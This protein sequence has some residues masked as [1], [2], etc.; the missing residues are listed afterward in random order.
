MSSCMPSFCSV[1]E[2]FLFSLV[3][4]LAESFST[5][6]VLKI[7]PLLSFVYKKPPH[8][9][10]LFDFSIIFCIYVYWYLQ[11]YCL[12]SILLY[13]L[14]IV[15]PLLIPYYGVLLLLFVCW[16][17]PGQHCQFLSIR[18][19]VIFLHLAFTSLFFFTLNAKTFFWTPFHIVPCPMS[20]DRFTGKT[21][22]Y[23]AALLIHFSLILQ[24]TPHR[25]F[26]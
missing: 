13:S 7:E 14:T 4:N 9:P 18:R 19:K 25:V 26:T 15:S 23:L 12:L 22:C 10:Q 5:K 2:L 3:A 17:V 1:L 8:Y 16:R 21:A 11:V 20:P 6:R 24:L